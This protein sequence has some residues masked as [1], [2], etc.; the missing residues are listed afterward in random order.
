[1]T[2]GQAEPAARAPSASCGLRC[3][4]SGAHR[5]P[6][7]SVSA[8]LWP[9]A[10]PS[11]A[12]LSPWADSTSPDPLEKGF[13]VYTGHPML[14]AGAGRVEDVEGKGFSPCPEPEIAGCLTRRGTV[15]SP[16]LPRLC[17]WL[18]ALGNRGL[19]KSGL[20][21][22]APAS[23]V[24]TWTWLSCF[25]RCPL[26]SSENQRPPARWR[27]A[28]AIVKASQHQRGSMSLS[29]ARATG[30]PPLMAACVDCL[31]LKSHPVQTN[32][33]WEER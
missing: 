22:T 20:A 3:H 29:E 10:L 19:E 6:P 14:P 28:L 25:V 33:S 1:M 24:Q 21:V 7:P 27:V 26:R 13:F 32:A 5:D 11:E 8:M 31:G 9:P 16:A 18:R 17:R 2:C 23:S 4:V 12:A 30:V 15:L